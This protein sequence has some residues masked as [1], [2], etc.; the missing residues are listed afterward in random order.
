MMSSSFL[1]KRS[2][3]EDCLTKFRIM[4]KLFVIMLASLVMS[5]SDRSGSTD[6]EAGATETETEQ[7]DETA[8][9]DTTNT[10]DDTTVKSDTTGTSDKR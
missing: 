2:R 7:T 10:S 6:N 1:P 9:P 8:S 4:K 5:C 3:K